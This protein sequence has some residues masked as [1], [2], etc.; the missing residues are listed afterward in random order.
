M[1]SIA[2]YS[3]KYAKDRYGLELDFSE[4]SISKLDAIIVQVYT[5]ISN[6]VQSDE[7]KKQLNDFAV[8]W[9]SYLGAYMCRKWGGTWMQKGSERVISILNIEFLPI[10]FI[11]QKITSHPEYSVEIY[12]FE[13]KKVIYLSVINPQPSHSLPNNIGQ[14]EKEIPSSK[15]KTDLLKT[16]PQ[17]EISISESPKNTKLVESQKEFPNRESHPY[18][19]SNK[20][21]PNILSNISLT[22]TPS[23]WSIKKIF[24]N[25]KVL[26]YLIAVAGV[27]LFIFTVFIGY[28][29]IKNN[30]VAANM[31]APKISETTIIPLGTTQHSATSYFTSTSIPTMTTL[32]TYTPKPT[33][34]VRPSSTPFPTLTKRAT[35]TTTV[36]QSPP[37]P[38]QTR[39]PI[40]SPTTKP[41]DPTET[42]LPPPEK[43]SPT[44]TIPEPVVLESCDIDPSTVPTNA[45]VKLTFIAHFSGNS[46]GYGFDISFDPEYSDQSSCSGVDTDGDGLAYC[47]GSSGIVTEPATV[48]VTF[49][50]SVGECVS[51]YTSR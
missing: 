45:N 6:Q 3:V 48:Y 11:Y 30:I 8:L 14:P 15:P 51:S 42:P 20:P 34:T 49:S 35:F 33:N 47:D 26:T 31:L 7:T 27:L 23:K 19:Q 9:G 4:Q 28:N 36:T 18:I 38:T 1:Q 13:A 40:K 17:N 44:P 21:Q 39:S 12:L 29:I 46:K 2:D 25:K 5:D 24:R 32:P 43:P 41:F 22:D 16:T 50:S 37:T 10:S